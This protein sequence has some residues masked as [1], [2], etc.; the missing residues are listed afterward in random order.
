MKSLRSC[1]WFD[2][3]VSLKN[4]IYYFYV[5][6]KKKF[7][8][9]CES[10]L[11]KLPEWC[12]LWNK[13]WLGSYYFNFGDSEE[14]WN[15]YQKFY[16]L[17]WIART[18]MHVGTR[19][20]QMSDFNNA[21]AFTNGLLSTYSYLKWLFLNWNGNAYTGLTLKKGCVHITV[22]FWVN[23]FSGVQW[24]WGASF[25]SELNCDMNFTL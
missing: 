18:D 6:L 15:K 25:E 13:K 9:S 11:N 10:S 14:K 1:P 4:K 12:S 22:V 7:I 2:G 8:I 24:V 19:M 16:S 3:Y 17:S 23:W 5:S 21:H 20:Y